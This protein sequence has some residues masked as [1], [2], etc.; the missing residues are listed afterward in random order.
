MK[1]DLS[2][3]SLLSMV[4]IHERFYAS[5][6]K[7]SCKAFRKDVYPTLIQDVVFTT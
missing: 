1:T 6:V 7:A 4:H 5:L 2:D 3:C